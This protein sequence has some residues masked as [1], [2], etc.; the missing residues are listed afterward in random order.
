[1][2]WSELSFMPVGLCN[3]SCPN[4]TQKEW[5]EDFPNYHMTPDEVRAICRRV[6]ELGMH[7]AWAHITGGEPSL[8]G[9][10]EEGCRIIR[11]SGVFDHIEVRSNCKV[12]QSLSRVLD[13][14]LVDHVVT[15]D[16]NCN[17]RGA[18]LLK[19]KYGKR[20]AIIEQSEHRV[21]P[22]NPLNNVL[23]A[24]CGCD[25]VTIFNYRVYPCANMYANLKRMGR[26]VIASNLS[27]G[28]E[29]NWKL[30]IE[31]INR[32]N[33]DACKVCL[34]NGKVWKQAQIGKVK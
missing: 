13:A 20:I 1:M 11:E 33:M 9:F 7:F 14:G 10:L 28:I 22:D 27:I 2:T 4:C 16:V 34:A 32:F 19:E 30:F 5:M 21:H 26:D 15:Q 29:H 31:G 23:P 12:T 18:K 3:L 6:R 8:W 17:K 25:R 24:E